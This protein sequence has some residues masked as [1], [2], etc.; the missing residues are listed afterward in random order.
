MQN[1]SLPVGSLMPMSW[2]ANSEQKLGVQ[3][4]EASVGPRS[5]TEEQITAAP[6]PSA[7]SS[8]SLP[9]ALLQQ[10]P[11]F[12][13]LNQEPAQLPAPDVPETLETSDLAEAGLAR[14]K[15]GKL[16]APR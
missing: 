3:L 4:N 8:N 16:K 11:A 10:C 12:A 1:G 2:I 15:Q 9:V 13:T 5:K 6:Q 14:N 7:A